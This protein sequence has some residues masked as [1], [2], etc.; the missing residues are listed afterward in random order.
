LNQI[1]YTVQ[2]PVSSINSIVIS[3][4]YVF[5]SVT[6]STILSIA[7]SLT[8]PLTS[9]ITLNKPTGITES[10]IACAVDNAGDVYFLTPGIATGQFATVVV[11]NNLNV[12]QEILVMNQEGVF[13]NNAS[14]LTVDSLNNIW[15]VTQ[16]TPSFLVRIWFASGGWMYQQTNL[17]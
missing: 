1:Y 2:V 17:I 8:T 11:T 9:F 14:S 6:H 4:G 5:L 13:V 3:N 7:Y 15:V 12:I 10:S 16:N